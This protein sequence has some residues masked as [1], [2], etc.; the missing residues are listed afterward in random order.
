MIPEELQVFMLALIPVF[1]TRVSIPYGILVA[2]LPVLEVIAISLIGNL[3]PLPFL[4]WGLSSLEKWALKDNDWWPRRAISS[5][6]TKVVF[7]VRRR[8]EKYI[9][10]YGMLGLV[11]F[12]AVPLPGS[13]VWSGSLLAHV[14]GLDPKKALVAITI[15]ALAAALLIL[16]GTISITNLA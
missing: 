8:G 2:K 4:L 1:E 14:L 16:V 12:V 11:F 9:K 15:G 3:T 13:G 7:R 5:I 6:Y 10:R